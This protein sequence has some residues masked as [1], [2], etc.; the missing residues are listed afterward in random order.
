[1][2]ERTDPQKRLVV[3]FATHV[4]DRIFLFPT[5]SSLAPAYPPSSRGGTLATRRTARVGPR[6][7]ACRI[8]LGSGDADRR[9]AR[10]GWILDEFTRR[11]DGFGRGRE[12]V[13]VIPCKRVH[14]LALFHASTRS[15]QEL[16][17]RHKSAW[18]RSEKSLVNAKPK[19]MWICH[20]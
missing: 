11:W 10:G 6:P 5:D 12:E 8:A 20:N 19:R 16:R 9:D 14:R 18:F 2:M 7:S 4:N 15:A 1:M 17:R 13:P 3:E